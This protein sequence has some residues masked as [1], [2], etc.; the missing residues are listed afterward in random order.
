MTG[1]PTRQRG[2]WPVRQDAGFPDIGLMGWTRRTRGGVLR[3]HKGIDFTSDP[4]GCVFAAMSGEVV[5]SQWSG[6]FGLWVCI[7]HTAENTFSLYAHLSGIHPQA[8]RTQR[9][10][11][12]MLI[13]WT[14]ESGSATGTTPHLHFEV[15]EGN[16]WEQS[17]QPLNP[18]W[19]LHQRGEKYGRSR[20]QEVV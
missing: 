18:G 11:G 3:I 19:W 16:R 10:R 4:G 9:V 5:Q 7:A 8:S 20:P 2:A 6:T 13:G 12:G 15:R 17:A 1:L 14:G